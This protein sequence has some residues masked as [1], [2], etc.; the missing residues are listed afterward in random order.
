MKLSLTSEVPVADNAGF[1]VRFA[2]C[3]LDAMK[4][5]MTLHEDD[6]QEGL[7]FMALGIKDLAPTLNRGDRPD[8]AASLAE[9]TAFL[10]E[11]TPGTRLGDLARFARMNRSTARRKLDRLIARG[12]VR[13]DD[14]THFRLTP[15]LTREHPE[16]AALLSRH[17]GA[18]RRLTEQ[19]LSERTIHVSLN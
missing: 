16:F 12:L 10:S 11:D 14:G 5:I 19:L 13:C 8:D 9:L 1:H 7:L 15:N 6:L 3:L 4:A 2:I 18:Y 17:W